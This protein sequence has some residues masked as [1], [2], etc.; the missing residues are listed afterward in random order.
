MYAVQLAFLIV[1]FPKTGKQNVSE[2]SL[3]LRDCTC[4]HNLTSLNKKPRIGGFPSIRG[5]VLDI[6][7]ERDFGSSVCVH[8]NFIH[9][10]LHEINAKASRL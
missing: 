5:F 9:Q 1:H 10:R 6:F 2:N 3:L 8:D 4:I 7:D